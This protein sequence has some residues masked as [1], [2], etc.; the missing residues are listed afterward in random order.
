MTQAVQTQLYGIGIMALAIGFGIV[1]RMRPQPVR[2]DRL[3]FSAVLIVLLLGA[4]LI[5]SG[6]GIVGDP[7]ALLL[8]P[9]FVAAGAGLGYYL[10][11]TMKFWQDP[12]TGALWM[13]G[14]VIFAL[15]LVGT[16]VVRL[17]IRSVVSGSPFAANPAGASAHGLLYD[18]SADLLFLS[19]GL[20]VARAY[21]L[22]QRH[23]AHVAQTATSTP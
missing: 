18:L 8:I 1:R 23:R 20:W 2:P 16:I 22:Y 7:L 9:V 5:A 6:G 14:G 10:V 15:I 17:G 13:R 12:V 3:I 4:S 11:R 19:I 21:L